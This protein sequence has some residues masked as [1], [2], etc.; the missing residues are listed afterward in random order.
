MLRILKQITSEAPNREK[1]IIY[2]HGKRGRRRST[3]YRGCESLHN[4]NWSFDQ[5]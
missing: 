3:R 2:V 5:P 1:L 4:M